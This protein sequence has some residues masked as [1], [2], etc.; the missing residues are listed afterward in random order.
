VTCLFLDPNGQ[1]TA[2][3]EIEERYKPGHLA[4][5]TALNID[6]LQRLRS[7]LPNSV[8]DRLALATYDRTIRFNIVIVERASDKTAVVQPYLPHSRGIESPAL[9]LHPTPESGLF[10][11][12][13][14][15]FDELNAEAIRC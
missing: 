3:R 4:G 6:L 2:A 9:V 13:Q 8:Q 5:L 12:F 11:T 15:V 1:G 10:E 7:R 14:T